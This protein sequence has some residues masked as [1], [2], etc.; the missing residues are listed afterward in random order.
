MKKI[1]LLIL[2][3]LLAVLCEGA[4]S[5]KTASGDVKPKVCQVHGMGLKSEKV[6]ITYGFFNY[7]G[8]WLLSEDKE[9]LFPNANQYLTGAC[10]TTKDIK[11]DGSCERRSGPKYQEVMYCPLCRAAENAW[12][13]EHGGKPYYRMG[14]PF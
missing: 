3:L 2:P 6:R 10:K 4:L 13:K 12:L 9:K 7:N 11:E 1:Y 14:I 8:D 5:Q